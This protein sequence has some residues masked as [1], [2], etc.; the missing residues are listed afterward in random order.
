M[1]TVPRK[2]HVTLSYP[3]MHSHTKFGIS[4]SRN[5]GD[6][7]Q[8]QCQFKKLG[9][10]KINVTVTQGWYMTLRHPKMHAHTK[11]GIPIS[12]NIRDTNILKTRSGQGHSDL[13]MVRYTP[14][15]GFRDI[16]VWKC[17]RT[18]AQ[19]H[20]QTLTRVPSYKLRWAYK[21]MK[22]KKRVNIIVVILYRKFCLSLTS[23]PSLSPMGV[24]ISMANILLSETDGVAFL[25]AFLFFKTL[26]MLG[27]VSCF[28]FR[29]LVNCLDR[30][31]YRR[32]AVLT[33]RGSR[34]FCQRGYNSRQ[35]CCF[36]LLFFW[37]FR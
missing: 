35:C 32:S 10:V 25:V 13:K 18:D 20:R 11:F 9:Q 8:T 33:M 29:L 12:N 5:I 34:K 24:H 31:Q 14:P 4:I 7:H 26:C 16:P 27:N 19:T 28:C 22:S 21:S 17:E 2:C 23:W 36:F 3:T 15:G 1:V 6:M 30:D 37:F